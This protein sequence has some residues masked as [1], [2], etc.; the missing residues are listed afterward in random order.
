MLYTPYVSTSSATEGASAF[1]KE[2]RSHKPNTNVHAAALLA[3]HEHQDT[4]EFFH[5]QTE[6]VSEDRRLVAES[7]YGHRVGLELALVEPE[8]TPL[9]ALP[10]AYTALD[11]MHN[12]PCRSYAEDEL[13]VVEALS[14]PRKKEKSKTESCDV[15]GEGP[16]PS[17]VRRMHERVVRALKAGR[18]E[19]EELEGRD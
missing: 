8:W 4:Q 7:V 19:E 16:T 13:L 3:T 12:Y 11:I 14:P 15:E 9:A 1:W 17:R 18:I 6:C 2:L 5:L 10:R